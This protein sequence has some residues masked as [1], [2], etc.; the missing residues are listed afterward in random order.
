MHTM[1]AP[2]FI[3]EGSLMSATAVDH[4][5]VQPRVLVVDDTPANLLAVSAILESLSCQVVEARSGLA[6]LQQAEQDADFA[7]VLLDIM[8]PGMDG[9]ETLARLRQLT[10]GEPPPVVFLT[11]YDLPGKEIDRAYELG[12]IDYI[13]KP[14]SPALLRGKVE[15]FLALHRAGREL[16]RQSAALVA[17]DRHIAVL[18]HDLRTPLS[19]FTV[20]SQLLLRN[21]DDPARVR[22]FAERLS[23]SANRMNEMVSGLLDY[24]RA[25]AGTIPIAPVLLDL[26]DLCRELADEFHLSDP[27]RHITV[28]VAGVLAGEWDRG[29]LYQA[30]SNLVGNATRYGGGKA[31]IRVG[32]AGDQVEIAVHNDGPPIP[33]ELLPII[34][35]PFERGLEDGAGLGLG[36]Y[37]VREIARLHGGEVSVRSGSEAGT[38]FFLRLPVFRAEKPS[39]SPASLPS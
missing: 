10:A 23:R 3:D 39:A 4:D 32:R 8:M 22:A 6:A 17:K 33:P 37:I 35:E 21:A 7:V 5:N 34:F 1:R 15:A 13:R 12:A 2:P 11:A 18:A 30:L 27:N 38:T 36:L 29:R 19:T 16:R 28:E 9:F 24:A 31:D 20:A 25:G 14:I 26:G